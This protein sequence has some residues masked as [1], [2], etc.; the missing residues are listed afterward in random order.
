MAHRYRLRPTTDQAS[1]FTEHC[2]HARFVWNL[3]LEQTNL[4]SVQRGPAP[5]NAERGRQLAEARQH[6]WLGEG[7][8][9]VQQQAL[10]DFDQAMKNWWGGTHGRPTWRTRQSHNSFRVRDVK[11]RK[12]NA[13]WGA[14][15]V[16]KIGYVGFRL[17]RPMPDDF[18]MATISVDHSGR[19]HVSFTA[20]Q[21][22]FVR[23]PTGAEVGLD[24]GIKRSVTSSEG[25]HHDLPALLTPGEAQRK[26][27][28]QRR[29]ARQTKGSARCERTL[30]SLAR[31]AAREV[32]RRKDW[33]EKTTT[34][35][36]RRFDF[37]AIEDLRVKNMTRSAAGT[38]ETPGTGV[39]RKR[40]LNRE[41]QRQA[42]SAFR[43]RLEQ[44]A[45]AATSPVTVVAVNPAF[46]SQRCAACGHT[47]K[48][49]R[50]SQA[51]FSCLVCGH[52]AN[53]DVNA[54]INILAAGHAVSGR[55]GTPHQRPCE[56]STIQAAA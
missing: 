27:R 28:L 49:N 48:G 1:R 45:E 52:Q 51:R 32:D 31:I 3:A 41:I 39:A 4:Y 40:G 44:K 22:D 30:R 16:P 37:V 8:S 34:D 6:S 36:V 46:T 55:G 20:P 9:T 7:S 38:A 12:V 53:A 11:V 13:R 17:S 25:E 43:R 26:R 18:G 33:I 42:W 2:A 47:E 24:L 14:I 56:A 23:S 10:R 50:E 54:A 35:L 19:W 21:P 29:S 5:N 15:F